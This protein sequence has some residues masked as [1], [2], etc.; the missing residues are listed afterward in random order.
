MK[1]SIVCPFDFRCGQLSHEM[2]QIT[3]S[4]FPLGCA[5]LMR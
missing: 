4:I 1:S 5:G 2:W 3:V